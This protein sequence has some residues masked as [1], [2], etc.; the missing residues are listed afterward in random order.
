MIINAIHPHDEDCKI[1]KA[2]LVIDHFGKGKHAV[3]FG[4]MNTPFFDANLIAWEKLKHKQP[5][6]IAWNF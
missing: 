1:V 4:I 2:Y 5:E 6:R 3:H